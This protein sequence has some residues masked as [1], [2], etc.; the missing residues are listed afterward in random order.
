[1]RMSANV[2]LIL[3]VIAYFVGMIL[4]ANRLDGLLFK[5]RNP[6]LT[7][8]YTYDDAVTIEAE[9]NQQTRPLQT[10]LMLMMIPV[11]FLMGLNG[12]AILINTVVSSDVELADVTLDLSVSTALGI[13]LI[14]GVASLLSYLV[15]TSERFR[16]QIA[17][18]LGTHGSFN[19]DSFV[20]RTA[21]ILAVLLLAYSTIEIIAAG[22][23][24]GLAEALETQEIGLFDAV[25][26]LVIMP[27]A[28][29]AR[30]RLLDAP[31]LFRDDAAP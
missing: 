21:L 18:W 28:A 30:C 13:A 7:Y 3:G 24:E 10:T 4:L 5:R 16:Q 2:I 1:V 15:L 29:L 31:Q 22:G 25:A 11:I 19:P 8:P 27:V 12:L 26:N 14:G 6:R 20:H 23:V 9:H 17:R